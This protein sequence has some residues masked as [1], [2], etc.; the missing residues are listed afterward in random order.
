[1]SQ[2]RELT[3]SVLSLYGVLVPTVPSEPHLHDWVPHK[4]ELPQ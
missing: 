3:V 1:M 2:D 4:P